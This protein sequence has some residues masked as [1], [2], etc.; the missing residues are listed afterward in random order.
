MIEMLK[1]GVIGLGIGRSHA[2]A[3]MRSGKAKVVAVCDIDSA[4][5]EK[6]AAEL[7]AEIC[8]VYEKWKTLPGNKTNLLAN[9][10]NHPT[11]EMTELFASELFE[12][13]FR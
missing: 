9:K 13:I 2:L 4:R 5:M 8:D 11:R 6:V 10:I 7:G 12:V 1:L 3:M